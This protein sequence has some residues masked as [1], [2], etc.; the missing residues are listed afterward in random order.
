MSAPGQLTPAEQAIGSQTA[1][2]AA[3]EAL[4]AALLEVPGLRAYQ[5]GDD[6]EPPAVL[7]SPPRLTWKTAS[8]Q[9]SEAVFQVV[10]VVGA[11]ERALE[12]LDAL[13]PQAAA[14]IDGSRVGVVL[15]AEPGT[16]DVGAISLPAYFIET[17]VA[18]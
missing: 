16:W 17:E 11:D 6:L 3:R 14:A 2:W 9:P 10:L 12:R 5:M 7:I 18:L 1:T 4:L 15:T 8:S 13:V